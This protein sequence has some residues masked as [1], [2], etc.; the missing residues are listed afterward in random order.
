M[1]QPFRNLIEQNGISQSF[2]FRILSKTKSMMESKSERS[3]SSGHTS[4]T[5]PRKRHPHLAMACMPSSPSCFEAA[6]SVGSSWDSS[7]NLFSLQDMDHRYMH[8]SDEPRRAFQHQKEDRP[9]EGD[10]GEISPSNG[11]GINDGIKIPT[12]WKQWSYVQYSY[13]KT[14]SSSSHGLHAILAVMFR[15]SSI[16]R[17]FV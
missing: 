8:V 13:Y 17:I 15:G 9:V 11:E 14:P 1:L 4:N 5:P 7:A 3:E 12:K 2:Y 6:A 16:T 10:M